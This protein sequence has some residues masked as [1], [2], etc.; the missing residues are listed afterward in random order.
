MSSRKGEAGSHQRLIQERKFAGKDRDV[1][2]IEETPDVPNPS[3]PPRNDD[4]ATEN[5]LDYIENYKD[6]NH[7]HMK[8]E[9]SYHNQKSKFRKR[10]ATDIT[11]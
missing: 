9:A 11:K 5:D 8:W 2:P 7:G 3:T 1:T 4:T 6:N 10:K